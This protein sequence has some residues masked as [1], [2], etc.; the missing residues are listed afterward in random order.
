MTKDEFY[1]LNTQFDRT[2]ARK[3]SNGRYY[4]RAEIR[5]RPEQNRDP[6]YIIA[7]KD[8]LKVRDRQNDKQPKAA[9][10]EP[11]AAG[12][13]PKAA[14]GEPKVAG[15]EPKAAGGEPKA[16][17]GEQR[18]KAAR[19]ANRSRDTVYRPQGDDGKGASINRGRPLQS[20]SGHRNPLTAA[21]V[22]RIHSQPAAQRRP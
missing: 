12:G 17:G 13:E 8:T 5:N 19:E 2:R 7:G 10:G 6:D 3:E 9:D 21:A 1:A 18:P 11:K 15:G 22:R 14:D 4:S 20:S 16:A